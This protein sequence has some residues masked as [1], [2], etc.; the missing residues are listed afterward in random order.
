MTPATAR[1]RVEAIAGAAGDDERAHNLE[2][3][4]YLDFV[5]HVA[6]HPGDVDL[7]GVAREVLRSQDIVFSR[8][9]A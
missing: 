6:A 1:E 2:D 8:W 7:A 4:L 9:C 5:A 3:Q